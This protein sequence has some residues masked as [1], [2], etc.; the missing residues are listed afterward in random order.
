MLS[1]SRDLVPLTVESSI[2][3]SEREDIGRLRPPPLDS[4]LE[5]VSRQRNLR[6]REKV[7]FT[8]EGP[9]LSS[10]NMCFC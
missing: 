4:K 10:L 7:P 1:S 2:Y 9:L 8:R 6:L 5:D 3:D